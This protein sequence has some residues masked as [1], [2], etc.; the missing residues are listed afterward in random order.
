M[1]IPCKMPRLKDYRFPREIVA[2][3]VWAYH[4]FAFSTADVENLLAERGVTVTRETVR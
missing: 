4:R 2:D 3:A 1:T